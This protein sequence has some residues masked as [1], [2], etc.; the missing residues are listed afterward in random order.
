MSNALTEPTGTVV[1][2]GVVIDVQSDIGAAFVTDCVRHIENLLPAEA[3][4]VKYGL[5][6]D[7]AYAGL[8]ENAPLQRAIAAAKVRRIHDGSASREKAQH[9]FL[10]APDVLDA[11]IHDP[12]SGPRHKVDAIRELRACAAAESEAAKA[13]ER[14]RFIININFGTNKIVKEFES[15]LKSKVIEHDEAEGDHYGA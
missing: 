8:S 6:D 1:L 13:V 12:G 9:K 11:I 10:T 3:L 5:L 7:E 4:R 15:P 14:E 2:R